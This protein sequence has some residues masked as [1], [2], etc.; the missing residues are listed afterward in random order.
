MKTTALTL[1]LIAALLSTLLLIASVPFTKAIDEAPQLQWSKTYG[2]YYAYSVIQTSDGGFA[3][4]GQ[5]ATYKPFSPHSPSDWLNFTALLIKTDSSGNVSWEKTYEPQIANS[6]VQT[7]DSGYAICGD[8][9]LLKLDFQGNVQWKRTFSDLK[10]CQ[11]IQTNDEG[12]VVFGNTLA[13]DVQTI[14][15]ILVRTDSLGQI[16]WTKNFT[17]NSPTGNEVF[18]AS[19]QQTSDNGFAIAGS[20]G[21]TFWFAKSDA[22][23]NL[24]FNLTY[25]SILDFEGGFN[26]ISNTTDGG[27]I[28]AGTD[29]NPTQQTSYSAW[30]VK[31][32]SNGNI[33]WSYHFQLS[34]F[35]AILQSIAET[36]DGGYVAAGNPALIKLN[37]NG[38]PEWNM[39][40]YNAY[41]VMPTKDSGFVVAGGQGDLTGP[42]QK[43]W[44]AKFAPESATPSPETPVPFSTALLIAVIAMVIVVVGIG[45][46]LLIYLIKKSKH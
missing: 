16:L 33:Q 42:D 23:G 20:W 46:G 6:V 39:T 18:V 30:I 8:N 1:I 36:T 28:L 3:I 11:A 22:A 15:S 7:N 12:F 14:S 29:Y 43:L 37:S 25:N 40:S 27:Y 38:K 26:S 10:N 21:G 4:A 45:L 24:D 17:S 41:S 34:G 2:P 19:V 35:G 32:D 9:S 44:V 31:T 13:N 5:N